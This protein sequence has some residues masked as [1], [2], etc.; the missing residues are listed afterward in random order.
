[1]EQQNRTTHLTDSKS[2]DEDDGNLF[3]KKKQHATIIA[4]GSGKD[5]EPGKT[6]RDTL[7]LAGIEVT[8][9]QLVR[10]GTEEIHNFDRIVEANDQ[11]VITNNVKAGLV[12]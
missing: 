8:N 11:I 6:L 3:P 1:M 4:P 12:A 9:Q 10:I 7:D 5:V 2:S